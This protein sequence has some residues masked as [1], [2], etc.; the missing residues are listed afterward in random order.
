[1]KWYTNSMI[2]NTVLPNIVVDWLALPFHILEVPT[3]NISQRISCS[4]LFRQML[5]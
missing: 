2:K 5:Q 4:Q 1:M 3:S